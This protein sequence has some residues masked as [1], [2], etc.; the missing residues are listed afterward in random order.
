MEQEK[1]LNLIGL[2]IRI[3]IIAPALL[4]GI[5]VMASGVN[6]ESASVDIEALKESVHFNAVFGISFIALLGCAALVLIFFGV[7]L[8]TRPASAIKSI[9][10]IIIATI[11]FFIAYAVGSTDTAESL[12]VD[13]SIMVNET[14][15]NFAT[16]GIWTAL[17]ALVIAT[18]TALGLGFVLKLV[19]KN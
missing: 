17:V 3:A 14:T 7:L 6:A 4:F 11:F 10:G 5:M 2:I 19:R 12:R 16:A 13:S 8:I 9:L 1:K 15:I 18:V